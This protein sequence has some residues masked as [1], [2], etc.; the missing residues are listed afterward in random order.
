MLTV[1]QESKKEIRA[2]ISCLI[3]WQSTCREFEC[4]GLGDVEAV[5][6]AVADQVEV[7][8]DCRACFA[9]QGTQA[10]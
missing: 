7:A 4:R 2:S 8:G 3:L 1:G 10:R 9:P 6:E 5:N